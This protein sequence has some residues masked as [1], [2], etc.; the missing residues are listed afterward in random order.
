M[1]PSRRRL[2]HLAAMTAGLPMVARSARA[3]A[4]PSRPLRLVV[5]FPAGGPNDILARLMAAGE[6]A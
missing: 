3:Q 5:G 1:R 2:L 4:Y 6:K